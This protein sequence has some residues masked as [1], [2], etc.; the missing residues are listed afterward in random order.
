[1][2]HTLYVVGI[3]A[4]YTRNFLRDTYNTSCLTERSLHSLLVEYNSSLIAD[5]S[6]GTFLSQVSANGASSAFLQ[7]LSPEDRSSMVDC[8]FSIYELAAE[9]LGANATDR[10]IYMWMIGKIKT[11]K[12]GSLNGVFGGWP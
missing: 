4:S 3:A 6:G 2:L 11:R 8:L 7:T 10:E 9:F 1:M 5:S 12:Y